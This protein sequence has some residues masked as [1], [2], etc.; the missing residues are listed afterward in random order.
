MCVV[1]ICKKHVD[2]AL[3][4]IHVEKIE[5]QMA[6]SVFKMQLYDGKVEVMILAKEKNADIVRRCQ[7]KILETIRNGYTW[8][9]DKGKAA[10]TYK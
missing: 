9:S 2:Y 8:C 4:W 10:G 6:K 3:D 1:S 5:N 7:C